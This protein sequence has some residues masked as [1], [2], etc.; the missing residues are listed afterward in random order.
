MNSVDF[1]DINTR[2]E[3]EEIL[4]RYISD[5][6]TRQFLL[7]NIYW[8]EDASKQMA[9]RFNL[10]VITREYNNIGISVPEAISKTTALFIR[11]DRSNYITET[12]L[13]DISKRFPGFKLVTVQDSGHWVH[14]EQPERFFSTVMDFIV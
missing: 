1:T 13:N 3:A 11:G 9:W 6:G 4:S 2:K 12:D 8:K 7:K 14:A 10:D 5:F